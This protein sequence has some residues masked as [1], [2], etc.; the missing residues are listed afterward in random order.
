MIDI[1]TLRITLTNIVANTLNYLP[2]LLTALLI[3]LLGW[4]LARII[5]ALVK[6]LAVRIDLDGILARTGISEG[7]K[8]AE[9]KRSGD[10]LV[11]M[12]IFWT[13]FLNFLLISME[14]LGL[15]AAVEPM[16][17]LIGLLP[18]LLAAL[19]TLII[20]ILIA[21]FLGRAAQAAMASMGVE[22]HEQIGG[23]VNMLLIVM[24]VIVVL[25][26]L[27]IDATILTTIFT[28]VLTIVVAGVALA[29]GLG[30]R[31][32]ARNV[33]AGF[34]AREQFQPGDRLVIDGE[35]GNLEGIGTL[36]AELRI[37][38]GEQLVI[39]NTRLT[40]EAV[41]LRE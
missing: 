6:R 31:E 7:L 15:T 34:Y 8:K 21:Q 38:D 17:N 1:E 33:L 36:N 3:L 9:I 19:A 16:R 10:E 27:G 40:Q 26:Q 25:E 29:F 4:L 13:I 2:R 22:F 24:V 35:E 23:G 14:S 37:D 11:G 41:R 20:G 32:V 28:N 39:P 12:L 5:A 30:G 18:R